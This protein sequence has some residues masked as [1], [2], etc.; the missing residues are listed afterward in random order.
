MQP[1]LGVALT[2]PRSIPAWTGEP[3]PPLARS[4]PAWT[5]EPVLDWSRWSIPAWTGEPAWHRY[6]LVLLA[7]YPR[8]GRGNLLPVSQGCTD[9]RSIP[10]WTG[11]PV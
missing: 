10:A 11:E 2:N 5:G 1:S 9:D 8:V 4:I 6:H 7:V 3:S